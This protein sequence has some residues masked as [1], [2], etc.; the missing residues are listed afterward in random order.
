MLDSILI[1]AAVAGLVIGTPVASAT[2]RGRVALWIVC[3]VDKRGVRRRGRAR[4]G[5]HIARAGTSSMRA[6]ESASLGPP[7]SRPSRRADSGR[8]G[9][10]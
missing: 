8:E 3:I 7:T 1:L 6:L 4:T 10:T 5:V 9:V 2:R